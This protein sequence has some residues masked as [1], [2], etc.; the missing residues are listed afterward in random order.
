M[1]NIRMLLGS[2]MAV[3]LFQGAALAQLEGLPFTVS[4]RLRLEYDDN[5]RLRDVDKDS[6]WKIVNQLRLMR[7][8]DWENT[9]LSL[10]YSPS[11][12]YWEN[13]PE[14]RTDIHHEADISLTHR[15]S[16]VFSLAITDTFRYADL[17]ELMADD[18][19]QTIL[20]RDN[21][22]IYNVARASLAARP[23]PNRVFKLDGAFTTLRYQDDDLVA[24]REDYDIWAV[25]AKVEQVVAPQ[26]TV[27]LLANMEETEYKG[28][29]DPVVD[30]TGEIIDRGRADRG[31]TTYQLGAGIQHAFS[32][33]ALG[34]FTGGYQIKD[35]NRSNVGSSSMPYASGSVTVLPSPRTRISGGASHSMYEADVYPFSNQD[36]TSLFGSFSQDVTQRLDFSLSAT[37]IMGRYDSEETVDTVQQAEVTDGDDDVLQVSSRMRYRFARNNHLELGYQYTDLSSDV[38][39]DYSRNRYWIGWQTR[40]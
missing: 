28:D 33:N 32:P 18:E 24:S 31:A 8:M 3:L 37:Y 19:L 12:I 7:T 39:L 35:F 23:Q 38:R 9:Y 34:S 16:P 26:T 27:T 17:P 15:F 13:R 21:T 22:Y 1:R 20:R 40:L 14:N 5:I 2:L 6:S 25:G 10:R 29:L 11:F 36:R 4:N 30:A